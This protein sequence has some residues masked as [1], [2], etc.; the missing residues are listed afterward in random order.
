M[1]WLAFWRW[2]V[3]LVLLALLAN[4]NWFAHA[5]NHMPFGFVLLL[6]VWGPLLLAS[7]AAG[8]QVLF[9]TPRPL[10]LWRNIFVQLFGVFVI[11]GWLLTWVIARMP[12]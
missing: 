8:L 6:I 1:S 5:G 12:T 7:A 2:N 11:L 10:A 3:G 4:G 9:L